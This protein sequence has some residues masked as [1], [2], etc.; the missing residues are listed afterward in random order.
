MESNALKY[1]RKYRNYKNQY[2]S[3]KKKYTGIGGSIL[4]QSSKKS[5]F[6]S[7]AIPVLSNSGTLQKKGITKD[8]IN[9]A[10]QYLLQ[11]RELNQLTNIFKM[12][13]LL[14]CRDISVKQSKLE[15]SIQSLLSDTAWKEFERYDK[16]I[17]NAYESDE[18]YKKLQT[19]KYILYVYFSRHI[20]TSKSN[21]LGGGSHLS[22]T[23]EMVGLVTYRTNTQDNYAAPVSSK[24]LDDDSRRALFVMLVKRPES[25]DEFNY[26][27]KLTKDDDY[28]SSY[29]QEAKIYQFLNQKEQESSQ[30]TPHQHR[31]IYYPTQTYTTDT[32]RANRNVRV[33]IKDM[34]LDNMRLADFRLV[35]NNSQQQNPIFLFVCDYLPPNQFCS[36]EDIIRSYDI[37]KVPHFLSK[38][39]NLSR[40]LWDKYRLFHGD[41]HPGNILCKF[42]GSNLVNGREYQDVLI[43]DFDM[44]VIIG[45]R[46]GT[47]QVSDNFLNLFL[48]E[49]QKK[50]RNMPLGSFSLE[51]ARLNQEG[52]ISVT[53]GVE[54]F[55]ISF[56]FIRLFVSTII[57]ISHKVPEYKQF[58]FI[59]KFYDLMEIEQ[60]QQA[61]QAPQNEYLSIIQNWVMCCFKHIDGFYPEGYDP[62]IDPEE[63][64]PER[65]PIAPSVIE[66][67][68]YTLYHDKIIKKTPLTEEE[69]KAL[70]GCIYRINLEN[71]LQPT[72]FITPNGIVVEINGI[73]TTIYINIRI[74][75]IILTLTK[76]KR[77]GETSVLLTEDDGLREHLFQGREVGAFKNLDDNM[78]WMIVPQG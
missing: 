72:D 17:D 4:T 60:A 7:F 13:Y 61:P 18:N 46:E 52:I 16:P 3:L 23:P 34:E 45:G 73:P 21:Q 36:F 25:D 15:N 32:Y 48:F 10:Y 40:I 20:D 51:P 27:L 47:N 71:K 76:L 54:S 67:N 9:Q 44:S 49:D 38:I 42:S 5:L 56:D 41:L 35:M 11:T 26:I 19:I 37:N 1:Y 59:K 75:T 31:I 30:S 63:P 57:Y 65:D 53:T 74:F 50:L 77:E 2:H 24:V 62:E 58:P 22:F 68:I 69:L 39:V 66:T 12:S 55:C 14:N 64:L 33:T 8:I 29:Q 78:N 70:K 6:F 43:F 28:R